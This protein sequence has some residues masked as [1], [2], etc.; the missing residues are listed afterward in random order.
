MLAHRALAQG[1]VVAECV[2]GHRRRF[3]ALAIAAMCFT[4]SELAAVGRPAAQASDAGIEAVTA[5]FPFAYDGKRARLRARRRAQGELPVAQWQ[6]V[7]P[8]SPS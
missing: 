4:D 3:E 6:A 8:G 7:E 5:V 2:A 1:E